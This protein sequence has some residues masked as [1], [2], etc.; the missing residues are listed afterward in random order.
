MKIRKAVITA[1]GR[2]QRGLPLQTLVD[3]DGQQKSGLHIIIDEALSTG[4]EEICLVVSPGDRRAY[5][6]AAGDAA[7]RLHFAEQAEPRGYGHALYCARAFV[8]ADPFLHL[9]SDHL[10]LSRS[11]AA[12]CAQQLVRVAEAE[13]CSVSGVHPT[14]ENML[15]YYGVIGGRRVSGQGD[16][17]EVETVAEKPTPTEAEQR[18]TVP[19]LR[20][21]H[22]LCFFGMHVLTPAVMDLLG[23]AIAA[24]AEGDGPVQLS[25]ALARLPGRERY[26]ALEVHGRRFNIGVRYGLLVAQLALAL[27]GQDREEVMAQLI[28]LLAA[29]GRD[30]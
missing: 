30:G 13:E 9:V 25:H 16:L 29:R 11:A 26:L 19:G 21:G 28:E 20:A 12:R 24:A 4:V 17:Y 7:G 10:Y 8:G 27:D 6:D 2:S 5:Q 18:L 15:P 1:A 22:Y 23:E 14:R 3:R